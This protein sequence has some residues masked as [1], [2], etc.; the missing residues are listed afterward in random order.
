MRR[1]LFSRIIKVNILNTCSY[2]F[3]KII[4]HSMISGTN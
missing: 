3:Y 4:Q 1:I 2:N